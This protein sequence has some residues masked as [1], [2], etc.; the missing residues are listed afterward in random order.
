M[1]AGLP[2][3]LWLEG[4]HLRAELNFWLWAAG[5]DLD[6]THDVVER[7]YLAYLVVIAGV[8]ATSCWLW[9]LGLVTGAAQTTDPVTAAFMHELARLFAGTALVLPVFAAASW[10]VRAA[11]RAPWTPTPP[12]VAWLAQLNISTAAWSAVELAKH[13]LG[14]L[15]LFGCGGYFVAAYA[16]AAAGHAPSPSACMP[17]AAVLGLAGVTACAL[18]WAVGIM[19]IRLGRRRRLPLTL[20]ALAASVAVLAL[21]VI[22][23]PACQRVAAALLAENLA[24]AGIACAGCLAAILLAMVAANTI[25]PAALTREASVD[26][27]LYAVRRMAV[28]NPK[29]YRALMKSRRRSLKAPRF[30]CHARTAASPRWRD[31]QSPCS[32]TMKRSRPCC[33]RRAHRTRG[34]GAAFRRAR[35]KQSA[36]LCMLGGTTGARVLGVASWILLVINSGDAPRTL[37]RVFIADERN[38]FMRDHL[39]ISTPALFVLDTLPPFIVATCSSCIVALVLGV[40]GL[41]LRIVMDAALCSIALDAAFTLIGALEAS[42]RS[43]K[44]MRLSC[45]SATAIIAIVIAV[46]SA[47]APARRSLRILDR[48]RRRHHPRGGAAALSYTAAQRLRVLNLA[49]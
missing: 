5:T 18:S 43:L 38:R 27:S 31:R 19:R 44:R 16:T 4:K 37:A 49:I 28:Y 29:A 1:S 39:P 47:L 23:M 7:I 35:R 24:Y 20:A 30:A 34:R 6:E 9:L 2:A 41:P 46:A 13:A 45:E 8:A 25:T 22:A 32:G 48:H 10:S 15:L 3:L 12:D 11:W 36:A 42:E 26:A 21:S 17:Y 33:H 40:V 14:R